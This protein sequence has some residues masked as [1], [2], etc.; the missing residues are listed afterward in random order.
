[1]ATSQSGRALRVTFEWPERWSDART[2]GHRDAATVCR[3][4]PPSRPDVPAPFEA[5]AW[6]VG[7]NDDAAPEVRGIDAASW[8]FKRRC[9]V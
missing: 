8:N 7:H 1:M 6:T 4:G 5:F 2:V 3:L 9:V